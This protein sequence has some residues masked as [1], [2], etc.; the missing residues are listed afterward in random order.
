MGR[1]CDIAVLTEL[2]DTTG[3]AHEYIS[4]ILSSMQAS[5]QKRGYDI[6]FLSSYRQNRQTALER[7]RERGFDGVALVCMDFISPDVLQLAHSGIPCVSI[8]YVFPHCGSV[9]SDNESGMRELT[10]YVCEMGH[11]RVA[12]IAGDEGTVSRLRCETFRQTMEGHD[13]PLPPEYYKRSLFHDEECSAQATRELLALPE[14]PT[15]IFYPDDIS[16]LG[17][18]REIAAQGLRIPQDISVTGFDGIAAMQCRRP[19]LTTVRQNA[20]AIGEEA[21]RQLMAAIEAPETHETRP[22]LIPGELL[23]GETVARVN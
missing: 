9:L 3:L 13:L 11:Q 19:R 7:C 4:T 20:A 17:G 16:C 5:A 10:E 15:C 14:R 21:I 1:F 6:T 23:K 22:V 18:M 8:D 12:Y 2:R